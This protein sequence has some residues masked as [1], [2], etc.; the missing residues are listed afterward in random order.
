MQINQ[1]IA[2]D[3]EGGT[4]VEDDWTVRLGP[5]YN[6]AFGQ[7]S[8]GIPEMRFVYMVVDGDD[9]FL[10]VGRCSM[11]LSECDRPEEWSTRQSS[12]TVHFHPNISYADGSWMISYQGRT[13]SEQSVA[14]FAAEVAEGEPLVG[15][16]VTPDQVPCST[17]GSSYWGDYDGM[18]YNPIFKQFI[19]PYS[20][21]SLGCSIRRAFD[22]QDLHVSVARIP[23]PL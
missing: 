16:Q 9:R 13:Q 22:Q 8:T 21:S 5:M 14:I 11:N 18:A 19:R 2:P 6:L 4:L 12:R 7:N 10:R 1:L 23:L 3:H 17:V 15:E 20:D